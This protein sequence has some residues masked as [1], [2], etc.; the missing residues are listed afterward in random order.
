MI[1]F[2]L[3]L[4]NLAEPLIAKLSDSVAPEVHTISLGSQLTRLATLDRASSVAS[5]AFHPKE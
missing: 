5:S 3:D 1:W 2:P 4:L